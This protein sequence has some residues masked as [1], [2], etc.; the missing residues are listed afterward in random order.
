MKGRN[1]YH[2]KKVAYDGR[3]FD[4]RAEMV[5]YK[6]LKFREMTGAITNLECQVVYEIRIYGHSVCKYVADF[7]YKEVK[8]GRVVVEDVKSSMT[9]KL[10]VYRLKKRLMAAVH[11]V[12]ISEVVF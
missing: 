9:S 12:A 10:P 5:R 7:R 2:A 6:A 3:V 4:S 8:S 1:K 11:N